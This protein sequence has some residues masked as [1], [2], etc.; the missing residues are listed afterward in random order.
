MMKNIIK[1]MD[2]SLKAVKGGKADESNK[3]TPELIT[4]AM[5]GEKGIMNRIRCMKMLIPETPEGDIKEHFDRLEKDMEAEFNKL[6][7]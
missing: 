1:Y 5:G 2:L 4:K 6:Q 7:N 3:I